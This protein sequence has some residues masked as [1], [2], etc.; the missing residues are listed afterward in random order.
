MNREDIM[1]SVFEDIKYKCRFLERHISETEREVKIEI[2]DDFMCEALEEEYKGKT[3]P[4][5]D[6]KSLKANP[7][8]FLEEQRKSIAIV[9]SKCFTL[10]LGDHPEEFV[11]KTTLKILDFSNNSLKLIGKFTVEPKAPIK[12]TEVFKVTK[13]K[14]CQAHVERDVEHEIQKHR[15]ALAIC[16]PIKEDRGLQVNDSIIVDC[17]I[18]H[19]EEGVLESLKGLSFDLIEEEHPTKS[20]QQIQKRLKATHETLDKVTLSTLQ[21]QFLLSQIEK[22]EDLFNMK[23]GDVKELAVLQNIDQKGSSLE[24]GLFKITTK[25]E[26]LEKMRSLKKSSSLPAFV[27]ITFHAKEIYHKKLPSIDPKFAKSMGFSSVQ[28]MYRKLR[29][30]YTDSENQ[31][32]QTLLYNDI[33]KELIK[34]Q[35]S[36]LGFFSKY[37]LKPSMNLLTKRFKESVVKSG[38]SSK[39]LAD[40]KI[41]EW[42]KDGYIKQRATNMFIEGK[43]LIKFAQKYD[44]LNTILHEFTNKISATPGL[45]QKMRDEIGPDQ[46]IRRHPMIYDLIKRTVAKTLLSSAIITEIEPTDRDEREKEMS[47]EALKATKSRLFTES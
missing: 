32:I 4:W 40:Q 46:D 13:E 20:G 14:F 47:S 23:V 18:I 42:T 29:K 3:P 10:F 7:R 28:Q 6:L 38:F 44:I 33:I 30:K 25:K 12:V 1:D 11:G 31:R 22:V 9:A 39:K 17:E 41:K 36:S 45:Y 27:T 26:Y 5:K 37:I 8:K 21:N 15:E 2:P 34:Q 43:T 35:P 16:K 24:E 19:G